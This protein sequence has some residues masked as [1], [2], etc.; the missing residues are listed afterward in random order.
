MFGVGFLDRMYN[1]DVGLDLLMAGEKEENYLGAINEILNELEKEDSSASIAQ[2]LA[3]L[4]KDQSFTN[5]LT[6][7][8]NRVTS[9]KVDPPVA[10]KN[11]LTH[12]RENGGTELESLVNLIALKTLIGRNIPIGDILPQAGGEQDLPDY[13]E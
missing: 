3:A 6:I 10:V 2:G 5:I 12:L 8:K 9:F 7:E 4:N 13:F 1:L 11:L